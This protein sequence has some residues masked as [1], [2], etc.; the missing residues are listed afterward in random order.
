[1]TTLET[2]AALEK[3]VKDIQEGI[4]ALKAREGEEPE[5]ASVE[6]T[7]ID[8]TI[9]IVAHVDPFT[10]SQFRAKCKKELLFNYQ[11]EAKA[12]ENWVHSDSQTRV[13]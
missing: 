2:I 1:M 5:P 10:A 11:G 12:I 7:H 4:A 8:A 13:A 9:T 6:E 3:Q